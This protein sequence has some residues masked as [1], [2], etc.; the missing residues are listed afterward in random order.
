[1]LLT[2]VI[3]QIGV[4]D[5]VLYAVVVADD[6]L[7]HAGVMDMDICIIQIGVADLGDLFW[8]Y[9]HFEQN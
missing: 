5:V 2:V 7:Q 3:I 8:C 4:A 6:V 1:M 9:L